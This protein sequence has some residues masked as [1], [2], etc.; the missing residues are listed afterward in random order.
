MLKMKKVL[1]IYSKTGGGHLSLAQGLEEVLQDY[2][3][4]KF[5]TKLIDPFPRLYASSYK[6]IGANLQDFWG[7]NYHLTDR[8]EIGKAIHIL[9]K[10]MIGRNLE[11]LFRE[12]QPQLVI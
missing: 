1:I 12:E 2:Y 4:G 7:K 8:P 10:L 5:K 11:K 6:R 9:N 3:P